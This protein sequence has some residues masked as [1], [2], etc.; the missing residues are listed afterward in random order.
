MSIDSE[1]LAARN[2]DLWELRAEALQH[3]RELEGTALLLSSVKPTLLVEIGTGFGGWLYLMRPFCAPRLEVI[4]IDA[5]TRGRRDVRSAVL[6]AMRG[7]YDTTIHFLEGFS[8]SLEIIDACRGLLHGRKA[9]VLMIDGDHTFEGVAADWEN[10]RGFVRGGGIVL[11]HD[12]N[13]LTGGGEGLVPVDGAPRFWREEVVPHYR[14]KEIRGLH[15]GG[16]MGVGVVY[17]DETATQ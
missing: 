4:T 3:P 2:R 11:F 13:P 5:E 8:Q 17:V 7:Q 12:I 10:Y 9:D 6:E 16:G 1:I 15:T 14:T